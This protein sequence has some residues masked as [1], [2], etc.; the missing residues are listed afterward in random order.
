MTEAEWRD[1]EI[2]LFAV[3]NTLLRN[4]WRIIRWM[5]IGGAVAALSVVSKEAQYRATASFIPPGL[6]NIVEQ[7]SVTLPTG[8]PSQSLDFYAELLKSPTLLRHIVHDT[9]VVEEM[10]SRRVSFLEL[11]EIQAGSE[12]E[13][14]EQG[15]RVL[16]NMVKPSMSKTTGIVRVSVATRWPS[17][18]VAITAAIMNGVDEFNRR[19]RRSQAAAERKFAEERLAI[20]STELREAENRMQ[21][22][23]QVNRQIGSSPDLSFQQNRIQRDLM[24]RQQIFNSLSQSVEEARLREVR[25]N[26]LITVF[27]LPSVPTQAEPRGRVKTTMLGIVVGALVGIVLA[28]ASGIVVRSRLDGNREAVEFFGTIGEVTGG[29]KG[30]WFRVRG[31]MERRP[32]A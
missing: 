24:L 14:E 30:L 11:F 32:S 26:P 6:A 8:S 31:L 2:S 13:R 4:R 28:F 29:V 25:D 7:F 27:E 3:G 18:S 22:F 10:A 5:V 15:L 23:L 21:A 12:R 20:A 9:L 19:T 16:T 1:E 17:V